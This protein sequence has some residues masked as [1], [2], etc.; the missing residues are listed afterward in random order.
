[1]SALTVADLRRVRPGVLEEVAVRLRREQARVL[2]VA[3]VVLVARVSGLAWTG[4]AAEA[5]AT[6]SLALSGQLSGVVS[7]LGASVEALETAAPR[8]R[9]ALAMLFRAGNRAAEE[10]GWVDEWG[11]LRLVPPVADPD[12]VVAAVRARR[13]ALLRAEVEALVQRS[14]AAAR[15]ADEALARALV[16]A[17]RGPGGASPSTAAP[18]PPPPPSREP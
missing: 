8:L 1:M 6:R 9:S 13:E 17:V 12:V 3:A 10:G 5:A 18:V 4:A 15:D 14:R 7:R 16:G 11:G 2:E